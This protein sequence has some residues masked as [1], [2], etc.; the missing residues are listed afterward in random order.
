[1]QVYLPKRR[2]FVR[3]QDACQQTTFFFFSPVTI[4]GF[5]N[6]LKT[7]SVAFSKAVIGKH[8]KALKK[9]ITFVLVFLI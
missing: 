8:C 5:M 2:V 7:R 6:P 1:M 4:T 3:L 9:D